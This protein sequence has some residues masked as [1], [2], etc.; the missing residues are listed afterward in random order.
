MT[1][2]FSTDEYNIKTFISG[3]YLFRV[4]PYGRGEW[5][6]SLYEFG[7]KSIGDNCSELGYHFQLELSTQPLS[8]KEVREAITKFLKFEFYS[9]FNNK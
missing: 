8:I 4:H 7:C 2:K 3:K 5:T 1:I 9:S 6:L